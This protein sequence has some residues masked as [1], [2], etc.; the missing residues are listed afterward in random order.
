VRKNS[1][2]RNYTGSQAGAAPGKYVV[3][4]SPGATA[5]LW[6]LV[7]DTA[8]RDVLLPERIAE[9]PQEAEFV[10]H[11]ADLLVLKPIHDLFKVL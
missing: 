6:F 9:L 5:V 3:F 10:V 4:S 2:W 8:E 1:A 11:P 7:E